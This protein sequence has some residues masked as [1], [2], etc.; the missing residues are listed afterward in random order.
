MCVDGYASSW[1][2]IPWIL[3]SN[4]VLV[5]QKSTN[6]QWFFSE[7]IEG[8]HYLEIPENFEFDKFKEWALVNDEKAKKIGE[9]GHE[10]YQELFSLQNLEGT[11]FTAFTDYF[12]AY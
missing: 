5:K 7:M 12:E 4:S 9:N 11:V 10:L 2:R 8:E 1:G 3:D 6:V